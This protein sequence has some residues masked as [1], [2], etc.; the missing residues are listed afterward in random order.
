MKCNRCG[1]ENNEA[2]V[3]C[4]SCGATLNE[5]ENFIVRMNGKLNLLAVVSG[6]IVFIIVLFVTSI[7]FIGLVSSK[8]IPAVVYIL[9]V[10]VVSVFFG[11]ILTGVLGSKT[12]DDGYING[13][14]LS[15]VILVLG[16]I[17]MSFIF[18]AFMGVASVLAGAFGPTGSILGS[19]TSGAISSLN[20][21]SSA[22]GTDVLNT[23]LYI[24]E[25]IASLVLI[26]VSGAIGG[27]LG[28]FIKNNLNKNDSR[29]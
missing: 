1:G 28:V 25:I 3:Y 13:G 19:G 21:T 29:R 26:L 16:G 2:A 15:L 5:E 24:V 12:I 20:T 4:K 23:I 17:L 10:M 7:L 11:S 27:A 6:L 9:L 22:S 8:T 18:L 14:F